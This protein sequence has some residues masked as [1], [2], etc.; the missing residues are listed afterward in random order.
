MIKR[1]KIEAKVST[2]HA[3]SLTTD[4]WSS[5]ANHSYTG[6]TVHYINEDFNPCSHLFETIEFSDSHTG[7]NIVEELTSILKSRCLS[8]ENL[9]L[10]TTDNGSNVV[11]AAGLLNWTRMPCFSHAAT[12]SRSSKR[13]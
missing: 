7:Q 11:S 6:L 4:I 12:G 5:R 2:I 1:A 9:V 3:Y 13:D 8:E 10:I